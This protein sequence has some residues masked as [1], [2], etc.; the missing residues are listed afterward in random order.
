MINFF[1]DLIK[2]KFHKF[3]F[4]YADAM[5]VEEIADMEHIAHQN[6]SKSIRAAWKKIKKFL[7]QSENGVQNTPF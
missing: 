2:I 4:F 3:L 7:G 5:T 1:D 6:V